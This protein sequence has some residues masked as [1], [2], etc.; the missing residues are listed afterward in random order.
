VEEANITT[1]VCTLV[2]IEL[3]R[4]NWWPTRKE[5]LCQRKHYPN[6]KQDE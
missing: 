5:W 6:I 4:W 1:A 2:W 3:H